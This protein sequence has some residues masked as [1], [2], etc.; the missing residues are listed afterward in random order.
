MSFYMFSLTPSER[1]YAPFPP[2]RS[3]APGSRSCRRARPPAS[4]GSGVD[5]RE[6]TRCRWTRSDPAGQAGL[7]Y[8]EGVGPDQLDRRVHATR[9]ILERGGLVR[10]QARDGDEVAARDLECCG[11]K[12]GAASRPG[13][14]RLAWRFGW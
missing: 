8:H 14:L 7:A 2:A 3:T 6:D 4:A 12:S 9:G 5:G 10:R 1:T 13:T 11:A